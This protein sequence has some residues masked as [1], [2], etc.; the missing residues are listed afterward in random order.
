MC[1][2]TGYIDLTARTS[3]EE[4]ERTV[5][6]MASTL[7]H[8]GPDDDGAWTDPEAGVALG[9][10]RLAILDLS[11]EGAQPMA[12]ADG[13]FLICFNGE[14]YNHKDLRRELESRGRRFRGHSDT[15]VMVEAIAE[16][17]LVPALERFNGMF[18]FA[19]WDTQRRTLILA[20]DRMG[21]KPLYYGRLGDTFF[22][23]SELKSFRPHPAW[24]PIVDRNALTLL[25]R[26]NNV[27]APFSIFEKI[28]KLPPATFLEF[29]PGGSPPVPKTYW[30]ALEAA[31]EGIALRGR[32]QETEL[33]EDLHGLLTEAIGLRMEA[34]VPLGA[35]LSG[36][37]DSSLVVALMQRQSSSP[38]RTFS[39]GFDESE[40][41]EAPAAM[42]VAR[43]LGTDHTELYVTPEES[44][45]VIPKLSA[46]YDE[47]FGDSSQVPTALV[48]QLARR[49]VTVSLSGDGGDELFGGYDRYRMAGS[50]LPRIQKVP[51][52]L[53]R[54]LGRSISSVSPEMWV[55]GLKPLRGV[56]PRQ[57]R[58]PAGGH[59]VHRV[60]D[61]LS[62]PGAR[63][64][65]LQLISQ[66]HDPSAVV[67]GGAEP[68]AALTDPD[69]WPDLGSMFDDV[70]FMDSIHYLPNDILTKVDRASMSASLEARVPLLDHRVVEASWRLPRHMKIR[71]GRGKWALR[72][73]LAR[74][75]PEA[76]VDRPKM[77]FGVPVGRWFTGPLRGWAEDLLDPAL[78]ARQG[79]FD[80]AP[81]RAKWE[82]HISG[83][84]NW[85]DPLW[86]V[87][88]FQSWIQ[89]ADTAT[90]AP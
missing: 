75:V 43:H 53:R 21:E 60:A 86:V 59:R 89:E 61:L 82:E 65:Y 42:E 37:I 34:D 15:E 50:H 85:Q 67:L 1:G 45:A 69:A 17:G 12:S 87:L 3:R 23:G 25:L 76:L 22:F 4:L 88:M 6:K 56:I 54:G 68:I 18:A 41:N 49:H 8:R 9:F 32:G 64:M 83:Q 24:N 19:V 2:L 77:G 11:V 10:R 7:T 66:W 62:A 44:V 31:R 47:P 84:R 30:S 80:P 35:F 38:V 79:F 5:T 13:R 51:R 29:T 26:Y 55:R 16:W 58:T 52:A 40:F 74:H 33:L 71:D 72:Q 81:I 20:R 78:L 28:Y 57:L 46:I 73:L 27:P 39:I 70:M 90:L 48:S 63:D 36:G 14:I